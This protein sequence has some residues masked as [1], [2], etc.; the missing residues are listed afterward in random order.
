MEF[1]KKI[2]EDAVKVLLENPKGSVD[3]SMRSGKTKIGL[4]VASNFK[5]VL[6]SYPNKPI[7]ES[8]KS[9]SAKFDISDTHITYTTHIS[10]PKHD[11]SKYDAIILD[12]VDQVSLRVFAYLN[13]YGSLRIYGLSGTMPKR[14]DKKYM[15]DRLCPIVYTKKL[16]E[17]T[18]I[19]NKD[20]R[21]LVHRILP[22][23]ERNIRLKSGKFWS[24]ADR[25][26]F[27]DTKYN[28]AKQ[29]K[30]MLMLMQAI[31]YSETK[32]KYALELAE[33]MKRGLVFLETVEQCEKSGYPSYHSKNP[34]SEKNLELFQNQEINKLATIGQLKAGISFP[35]LDEAV[36]MHSYSSSNRSSQKI[37][38][39]LQYVEGV[40]ATIHIVVLKGTRDEAWVKEAL[41]GFDPFKIAYVE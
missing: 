18:G 6:V 39:C 11:L 34:D 3:L 14:G 33:E 19:T 9:D 37:G 40:K 28:E 21:I 36:L 30:V 24:E 20:Y 23:T 26:R 25:I 4:T 17:T 13:S 32:L 29:F 31:A 38:R 12:E 7:Y 10:L 41:S 27:F 35:V 22:S 1:R 15:I 5:K 2:Q 8:W 16:D